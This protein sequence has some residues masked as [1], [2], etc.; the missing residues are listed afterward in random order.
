MLL[1]GGVLGNARLLGRKTVE[2]MTANHWTGEK[3]PFEPGN[4][5][6][7]GG[8]GFGLGVRTLVDAAQSGVPSSAG[9]YG[10]AGAESTYFWID[11]REQLFGEFMVQLE[12]LNLRYAWIFQVLAYQALVA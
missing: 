3:S 10:W 2:L 12:P 1:D 4:P 11:P 8:N 9:E 6:A 5:A 7:L